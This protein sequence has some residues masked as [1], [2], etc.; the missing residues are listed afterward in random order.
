[1]DLLVLD[2]TNGVPVRTGAADHIRATIVEVEAVGVVSRRPVGAV[3]ASTE[4]IAAVV[5]AYAGSR[6]KHLCYFA[7]I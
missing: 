6:E 5:V 2:T 1:M 3:G 4:G 7:R